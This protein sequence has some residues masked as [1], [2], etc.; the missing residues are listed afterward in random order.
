MA[1]GT[2][3]RR[4]LRPRRRP[5]HGRTQGG[6]GLAHRRRSPGRSTSPSRPTTATTAG[7]PRMPTV[8]WRLVSSAARRA[9]RSGAVAVGEHRGRLVHRAVVEHRT[10]W[11]RMGGRSDPASCGSTPGAPTWSGRRWGDRSGAMPPWPWPVG[12]GTAA[13]PPPRRVPTPSATCCSSSTR[14]PEVAEAARWYLEPVDY[15]SMRF[16]G[17]AAAS[18]ASMAGAWLTDNR[19]PDRL[20]Y[21]PVLVRASGVPGA[22][23]APLGPDLQRPGNRPAPRGRGPRARARGGGGG[24]HPRSALGG[25]RRRRRPRPPGPPGHLDHQLGELSLSRRRRPI[26]SVRWPPC[27]DFCPASTWWPTT[28]SRAAVPSSGCATAWARGPNRGRSTS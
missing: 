12:S 14:Q 1:P 15:L 9:V 4:P 17:V 7:S 11:A 13:A 28:R 27:P 20:S 26:R 21:D 22:E 24:G 19:R 6:A 2:S 25:G 5:G 3:P 18:P 23:A 8:W 10:R 16:S